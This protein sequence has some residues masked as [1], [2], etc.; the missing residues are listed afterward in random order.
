MGTV[1]DNPEDCGG[2]LLTTLKLAAFLGWHS[3]RD[4]GWGDKEVGRV[5]V[6][7]WLVEE[8][9]CG[10]GERSSLFIFI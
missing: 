9:I 2:A 5:V 4:E 8:K 7:G 6:E 1:A 10:R 3:W